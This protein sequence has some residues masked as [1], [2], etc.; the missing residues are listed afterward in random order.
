MERRV[1]VATT[2]LNVCMR[3]SGGCKG[4]FRQTSAKICWADLILELVCLGVLSFLGLLS[5]RKRKW[6]EAVAPIPEVLSREMFLQQLTWRTASTAELPC[7]AAWSRTA[8]CSVPV[9]C[10]AQRAP[11]PFLLSSALCTSK[12]QAD[13]TILIFPFILRPECLGKI[14]KENNSALSLQSTSLAP[15]AQ[16]KKTQLVWNSVVLPSTKD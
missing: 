10:L 2:A 4:Q 3:C 15:K 6:R 12:F 5:S 14:Y 7:T 16:K 1:R 11:S 9:L 13:D 8:F